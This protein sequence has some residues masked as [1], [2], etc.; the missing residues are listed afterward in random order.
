MTPPPTQPDT[1]APETQVSGSVPVP[2][3]LQLLDALRTV[4]YTEPGWDKP[5]TQERLHDL[6]DRTRQDLEEPSC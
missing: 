6:L 5:I 3:V 2:D 4:L 1:T